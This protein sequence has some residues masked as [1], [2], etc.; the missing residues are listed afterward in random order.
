MIRV[1]HPGYGSRFFL[2][3]PD[4]GCRGQKGTGSRVRNTD[5]GIDVVTLRLDEPVQ[6]NEPG[7]NAGRDH[8]RA[9]EEKVAHA[10]KV[11]LFQRLPGEVINSIFF[12]LSLILRVADKD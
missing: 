1:V 8:A 9:H 11:H 4:A 3:I 2:P 10:A 5:C 12:V 7:A 6:C